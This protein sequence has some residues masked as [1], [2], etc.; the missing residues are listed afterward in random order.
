MFQKTTSFLKFTLYVNEQVN[1]T[2]ASSCSRQISCFQSRFYYLEVH[3]KGNAVDTNV[4][5]AIKFKALSE[6]Q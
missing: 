4:C 2:L 3:G 6:G 5:V 1:F